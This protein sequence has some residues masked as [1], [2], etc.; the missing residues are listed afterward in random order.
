MVTVVFPVVQ[1]AVFV[2][3]VR[4]TGISVPWTSPSESPPVEPPGIL[5]GGVTSPDCC[6][7]LSLV[8]GDTRTVG[9]VD[10]GRVTVVVL[11]G[12]VAVDTCVV[13]G[14]PKVDLVGGVF[15]TFG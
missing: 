6:R 13:A 8:V 11:I 15:V 2:D 9:G 10:P 12:R 5:P 4:H 7:G 1:I 14:A 3:N